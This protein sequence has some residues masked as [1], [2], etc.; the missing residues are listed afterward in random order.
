MAGLG[1]PFLSTDSKH[2]YNNSGIVISG[3]KE[4]SWESAVDLR[5]SK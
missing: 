5:S 1:N 3:Y 4:F 2:A